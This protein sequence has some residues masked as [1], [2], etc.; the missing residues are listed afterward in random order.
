[1]SKKERSTPA[2]PQPASVASTSDGAA[3]ASASPRP[4]TAEEAQEIGQRVLNE[5]RTL[6]AQVQQLTEKIAELDSERGEHAY[7]RYAVCEFHSD[8]VGLW[9]NAFSLRRV[10]VFV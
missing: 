1:M 4:A 3:A 8:A 6:R 2:S 5:Y 10:V 7:E 9:C